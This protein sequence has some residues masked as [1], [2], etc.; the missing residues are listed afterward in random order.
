MNVAPN[1]L[2]V[3]GFT[4]EDSDELCME[5]IKVPDSSEPTSENITNDTD[6]VGQVGM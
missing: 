5:V 4:H 3:A 6:A 2:W 1:I